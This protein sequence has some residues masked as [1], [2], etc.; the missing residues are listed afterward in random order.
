M[1]SRIYA[2][3]LCQD[4]PGPARFLPNDPLPPYTYVPGR[5][6]HPESN[7]A[8]HSYG[9]V[10]PTAEPIDPVRWPD[11]RPYLRGLDL[12]NAGCYW[13][14]HVEFESLWLAAGRRGEIADFFKGLI[15]L[16]AAGVKH[17]E[18]KT[19]GVQSH[20]RR[21]TELWLHLSS[22]AHAER[23]NLL[24][25]CLLDLITI[26]RSL[27]DQGWPAGMQIHLVP[28]PCSIELQERH[29]GPKSELTP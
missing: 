8:G 10:R 17:L 21:A 18:E 28:F 13:E 19:D 23:R 1:L 20:A 11:C 26:A 5:Q 16:A 25:F 24:G 9:R 15:H 27:T 12:F 3:F 7:P 29:S 22:S 4:N 14:S 6:P 2:S